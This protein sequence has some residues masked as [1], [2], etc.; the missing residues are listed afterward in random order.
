MGSWAAAVVMSHTRKMDTFIAVV[1]LIVF[2]LAV[3]GFVAFAL[4]LGRAVGS[5]FDA[6]IRRWR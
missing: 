1:I 6:F 2:V 4:D 3:V 5:W